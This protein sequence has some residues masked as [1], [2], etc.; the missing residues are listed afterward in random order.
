MLKGGGTS[1]PYTTVVEY[2]EYL[3][4]YEAIEEQNNLEMQ[5]KHEKAMQQAQ[6]KRGGR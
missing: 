4:V 3:D 1:I 5:Q 2:L 6:Q